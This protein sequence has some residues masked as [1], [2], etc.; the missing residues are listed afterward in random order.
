MKQKRFSAKK[1]SKIA[2]LVEA[3]IESTT[4]RRRMEAQLVRIGDILWNIENRLHRV[5]TTHEE[6]K[7]LRE[8]LSERFDRIPHRRPRRKRA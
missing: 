3:V 2:Q 8:F 7:A 6:I 5:T 4:A 1:A